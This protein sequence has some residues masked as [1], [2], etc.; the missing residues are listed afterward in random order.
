MGK[1]QMCFYS[2]L[3][4]WICKKMLLNHI[5][6]S[7]SLFCP[8]W[9]KSRAYLQGS[10]WQQFEW[11]AASL[12]GEFVISYHIVSKTFSNEEIIFSY[13]LNDYMFLKSYLFCRHLQN[14]QLSGILFVLQDLPL[15]DLYISQKPYSL[16]RHRN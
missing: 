16:Y 2:S 3:V 8:Q 6:I 4:W 9:H 13:S 1:S 12:N 10:V 5:D 14:N 11:S 15:Q 7:L